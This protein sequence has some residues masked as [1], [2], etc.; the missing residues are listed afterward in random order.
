MKLLIVVDY[1][2]DFISGTLGFE[3]AKTFEKGILNKIKKYK[4]E[5]NDVLFTM[6]THNEDYLNTQEGRYLPI[7]H[8]VKDTWGWEVIESIKDFNV[9]KIE[10]NTFGAPDLFSFLK[11]TYY[12]E[13]EL[14]GLVSNICVISNAIIA[15]TAAPNT[16]VIVDASLTG[17]NDLELHEKALDV[18]LGL[19]IDVINRGANN[20]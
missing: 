5:N 15:K 7:V 19:Q 2:N 16:R 9:Y 12:E 17:S 8:C 6:D 14:V 20:E 13:I 3:N 1:Q 18:M 11:N 10:K 4:E